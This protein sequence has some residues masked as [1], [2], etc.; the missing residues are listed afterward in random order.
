MSNSVAEAVGRT[1][2]LD[3]QLK[4]HVF[5]D[6]PEGVHDYPAALVLETSGDSDREGFQGL[7]DVEVTVRVWVLIETRRD[8][9][10]NV[11]ATRPWAFRLVKLFAENDE[12]QDETG[13]TFGEIQH[14]RYENA[15]LPYASINHTGIELTLTARVDVNVA[16]TCGTS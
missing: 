2:R 14:I 3:D 12:L 13:T 8:L 6:P 15:V 4:K 10:A 11:N 16:V 7:W 9:Q 5:V 1:L